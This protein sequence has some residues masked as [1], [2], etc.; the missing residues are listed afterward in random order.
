MASNTIWTPDAETVAWIRSK[1]TIDPETGRITNN[2]TG[3]LVDGAIGD[4]G[5]RLMMVHAPHLGLNKKVAAHRLA[6]MLYEGE[7]APMALDHI[8]GVRSDNRR[9]NLRLATAKANQGNRRK[10]RTF[11][12]KPCASAFKGVTRFVQT[13]RRWNGRWVAQIGMGGPQPVRLGVF[14]TEVE[15]AE[16]YNEAALR[17]HGEYA[18]LNELPA[19]EPECPEPAGCP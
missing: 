1:Y 5:Y 15:A 14:D 6:W 19:S 3:K 10:S 18:L 11:K 17:W 12:G 8:N 7:P 4:T 13:G 9:V 16:A 2:T